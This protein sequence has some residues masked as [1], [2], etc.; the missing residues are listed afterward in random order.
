MLCRLSNLFSFRQTGTGDRSR[1]KN[2]TMIMAVF[3]WFVRT[4]VTEEVL[5]DQRKAIGTGVAELV[6][7]CRQ[8]VCQ[9]AA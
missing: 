3:A 1:R 2:N 6:L 9:R 8:T 4:T 5:S 7:T